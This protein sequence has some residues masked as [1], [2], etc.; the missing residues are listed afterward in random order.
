[1]STK[2]VFIR[3]AENPLITPEMIRPWLPGFRVACAFNAGAAVLGDET[4]LLLRV[5]ETPPPAPEGYVHVPLL[6]RR[7]GAWRVEVRALALDD[8]RYDFSDPRKVLDREAGSYVYLSGISHLRLARSRDGVHFTVDNEPFIRPDCAMEAFGAEDPRITRIGDRFFINYTAVSPHGITTALAE[9]WD[10][11]SAAKHGVIFQ[12]EA[13]DVCI[14]PEII[15]GKYMA[16]TR[17][18]PRQIGKA[19]IWLSASPDLLHWGEF[20]PLSLPGFAWDAARSGGG[21]PPILTD[22]G[23]LVLYHGADRVSNRYSMGAALLK[24]DD[25]SRVLAVSPEPVLRAEADYETAGFYPNVVFSCGAIL[26]GNEVHMYYGAADR[27]TALARADLD[28]L[29]DALEPVPPADE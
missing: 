23:W 26:R 8:P 12:T 11:L 7:D 18:V 5:S 15:R 22:R 1:M 25:P 10:F 29:L 4:L 17:P 13:R 24:T 20:R 9:T 14:F 28:T 6:A 3:E 21:A 16:L 19:K 27:V 2:P